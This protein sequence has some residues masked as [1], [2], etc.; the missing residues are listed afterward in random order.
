MHKVKT[1]KGATI[2]KEGD[3][4]NNIFFVWKGEFQVRKKI[5]T[6][7]PTENEHVK[8]FLQGVTTK[9]SLRGIFNKKINNLTQMRGLTNSTEL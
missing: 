2:I 3:W 4:N 1:I 7:I 8:Q 9:R 6:D 5:R